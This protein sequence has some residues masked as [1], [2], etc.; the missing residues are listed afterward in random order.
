[1]DFL[2]KINRCSSS[3]HLPDDP[4]RKESKSVP[5]IFLDRDTLS[6]HLPALRTGFL[7]KNFYQ[8]PKATTGLSSGSWGA[9][10]VY[11]DDILIVAPTKEQYL[12]QA[13]LIVGLLEKLG[14][15]IN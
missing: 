12:E 3:R 15:V 6:V 2:C 5:A 9:S 4:C 14:Y 8:I 1:M 11:L 13:Q 7:T 10:L